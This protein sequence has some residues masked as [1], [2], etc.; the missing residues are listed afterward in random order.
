MLIFEKTKQKMFTL[1]NSKMKASTVDKMRK[2]VIV[3]HK[4]SFDA[5]SLI[6]D[7]SLNIIN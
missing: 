5:F 4:E 2:E 6:S 1:M 7:I 3:N